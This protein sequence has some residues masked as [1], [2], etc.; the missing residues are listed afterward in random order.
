MIT[1]LM[2]RKKTLLAEH[3]GRK[4]I[5]TEVVLQSRI[6]LTDVYKPC[7]DYMPNFAAFVQYQWKGGQHIRLSGIVRGLG[8]RR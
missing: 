3:Y 7:N 4:Q 2:L 1:R 6:E 8:S 5:G